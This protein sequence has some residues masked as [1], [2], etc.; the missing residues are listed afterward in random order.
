MCDF[1]WLCWDFEWLGVFLWRYVISCGFELFS[2]VLFG[3]L[4]I[5]L[6][7]LFDVLWLFV[8]LSDVSQFCKDFVE[9]E[10]FHLIFCDFKRFY[11][12]RCGLE[13]F[14]RHILWYFAIFFLCFVILCDIDFVW[15]H[16]TLC[17]YFVCSVYDFGG[18]L[19]HFVW[20]CSILCEF[21]V[22]LFGFVRICVISCDLC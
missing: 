16:M 13:W 18:I 9:L 19:R 12:I 5:F 3:R 1:V 10:S 7:L 8:I 14:C 20:F 22:T 6:V 2:F 15:S 11:V 17:A 21:W 4:V